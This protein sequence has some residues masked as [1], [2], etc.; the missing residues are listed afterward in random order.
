MEYDFSIGSLILGI[1][2]LAA[3]GAIVAFYR[4]ISDNLASGV[5]S[6]DKVKLV[7]LIV[8]GVGLIVA[9]SLHTLILSGI[10]SLV[11]KR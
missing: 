3:G 7:G 9:T 2:I 4:Q 8:M 1:V 10:V 11:F 5:S 6:Y